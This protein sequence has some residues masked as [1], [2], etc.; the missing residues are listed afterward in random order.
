MVMRV[1]V[2]GCGNISRV[3]LSMANNFA[4]VDFVAV[5]DA[6]PEVAKAQGEK[7]GLPAMPVA[8]LITGDRV[9]AI[10]NL[11]V[12]A[13][14]ADISL[15]ALDAGKHVFSE[16]PLATSLADGKR[17]VES[18]A[19]RGL[20]VGIAP[21]TFLGAG[22]QTAF[23]ML[24]E[25]RIGK[26]ILGTAAFMSHGMENWHPNPEFFFK[27]GGGPILDMGPYYVTTLAAMFGPISHVQAI[28]QIGLAERTVTTAGSPVLGSKIN[29][30]I[31]T[32]VQALLIFA[33]GVQMTLL[34]SWD[35]W[36][37]GM[38]PIE[39][40]GE[41]GSM[42]VP[43][44][45]TFGGAV[46]IADGGSDWTSIETSSLIFGM[47]SWPL[48]APS[49]ANYR[50]LGLAEMARAIAENRPHRASGDLGV[51]TLS[52]LEAIVQSATEGKVIK[53][54][55][56]FERPAALSQQEAAALL[57]KVPVSA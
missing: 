8:D 12:P 54:A 14:H 1:G 39:I 10:L 16:K 32:S 40:H 34:C 43:D 18:A 19:Q 48:D 44:P 50:G 22:A 46:E 24:N 28:G 23:R 21:D 4:D 45:N 11:T 47:P 26:P 9:D 27:P 42:R 31:L 49:Y 55:E 35:V 51:H 13:A 36:N 7:F 56:T 37:H 3:Y 52:V 25:G 5:S 29:V 30:E 2:V 33:S 57:K 6:L 41:A 38:L 53:I 15:A 17:I 20:R